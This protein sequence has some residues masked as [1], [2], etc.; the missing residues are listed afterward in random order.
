MYRARSR[1][2]ALDRK[3]FPQLP[4]K[5]VKNPVTIPTETGDDLLCDG[6]YGK[7]RKVHYM[8]DIY[9]AT[10]WGLITGFN[11][12]FPWFYAAFFVPM[13]IHRTLRDVHRCREKYG[14]AWEEYEKRVPYLFIPVGFLLPGSFGY[15]L[16]GTRANDTCSTFSKLVSF[17]FNERPLSGHSLR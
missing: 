14:K 16:H 7:A 9:F 11:S 10:M 4:Y 15:L 8:C 6:W 12:P 13:I 17:N 3:T 2:S 5:E 1:G